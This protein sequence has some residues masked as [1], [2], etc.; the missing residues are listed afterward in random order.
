MNSTP[1]KLES[2]LNL[3]WGGT[4]IAKAIGKSRRATYGMLEAGTL[5]AK[6]VG[7]QWCVS[8]KTLAEF[9]E[10]ASHG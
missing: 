3:I 6:R 7:G 9:F 8:R 10:G 4:A 1:I 5:P 2:E